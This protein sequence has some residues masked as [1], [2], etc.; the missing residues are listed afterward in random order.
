MHHIPKREAEIA[1]WLA[2]FMSTSLLTVIVFSSPQAIVDSTLY[3]DIF[4][5]LLD[6]K[7]LSGVCIDEAH[8]FVQFGLQFCD[9][10][11][12]LWPSFFNRL[13]TSRSYLTKVPVR[14]MTD[15]ASLD[16]ICQLEKLTGLSFLPCTIV[17]WPNLGEMKN[18]KII[19]V[20]W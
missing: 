17:L 8:L 20:C 9:E 18:R 15:T 14:F 1:E 16:I 4:Q 10:F 12:L 2:I 11:H 5:G 3:Q 7:I 6:R 13:H 19:C